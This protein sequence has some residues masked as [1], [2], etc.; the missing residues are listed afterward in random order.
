[1]RSDVDAPV[2]FSGPGRRIKQARGRKTYDA[3]IATAF[4][5]LEERE[6]DTLTVAELAKAAGYSVGAFYARFKSRDEFFDAMIA[7]HMELRTKARTHLFATAPDDTLVDELIVEVCAYFGQRERFWRAALSRSIRKP[8]FWEPLRRHGREFADLLIE[9]IGTSAAR[10]L[11]DTEQTNVR[12]AFQITL[13]TIN[14]TIIN[15]PG[16]IVLG[17]TSF[18]ANLAR[19]FRLVSG[20]D[21]LVGVKR[22]D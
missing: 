16:P 20:Y 12:F 10:P 17:Q 21:D 1:M 4:E 14:N 3:L 13:G 2:P 11:T 22:A 15:R 18:V 8:E 6:F 7:Q 19:A 9:R 5:L